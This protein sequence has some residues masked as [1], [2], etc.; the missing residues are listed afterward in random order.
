MV[1][2]AQLNINSPLSSAIA[3][4]RAT[5]AEA[6]IGVGALCGLTT[7]VN[8]LVGF[9]ECSATSP[10]SFPSRTLAGHFKHPSSPY[11]VS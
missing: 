3:Y 6:V 7:Y 9:G 1:N 4:H 2:Y 8:V 10:L 11:L 5:W